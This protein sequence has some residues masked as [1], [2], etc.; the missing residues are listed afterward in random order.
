MSCT[1][2]PAHRPRHVGG[3]I[4]SLAIACLLSAPA[5]AAATVTA[6]VVSG[7]LRVAS[8]AAGDAISLRVSADTLRI[9]VRQGAALIGSFLR[10]TFTSIAVG[11]GGGNDTVLIDEAGG[12]FTNTTPTII[13]GGDGNDS[14]TGG[15]GAEIISGGSGDDFINARRGNDSI[16]GGSGDDR[17]HWIAGAVFP[18]P[19]DG[20]D[21]IDG[22]AGSDSLDVRG[23]SADE[24]YTLSPSGQR[25]SLTRD[26]GAGHHQPRHN[27]DRRGPD[28]RRVRHLYRGSS[29]SG[30]VVGVGQRRR[31]GR[32]DHRK[33]RQRPAAGRRRRRTRRD[34]RRRRRRQ[35]PGRRGRR[36]RPWRPGQRHDPTA[37]TATTS[38][39]A[40]KATTPSA[41]ASETTGRRRGRQRSADLVR[42][43]RRR[44]FRRPRR[45]RRG[46]ARGLDTPQSCSSSSRT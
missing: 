33:L 9:E 45:D 41:A 29:R 32:L 17:F 4:A 12:S 23:N 40:T 3:C 42:G 15:I 31:R 26:V 2:S 11:A 1:Q 25:A 35:D 14:I 24:V 13:D 5:P 20:N 7:Q 22:G 34:Q 37:T 19:H 10:S 16:D 30:G 21:F 46:G 43:R 6:S 38:S 39:T 8:D 36:R 27:R 28:V 44:R 18:A